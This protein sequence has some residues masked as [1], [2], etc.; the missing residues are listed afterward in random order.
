MTFSSLR[1]LCV[2]C[3]VPSLL[4]MPTLGGG[5]L[6]DHTDSSWGLLRWAS[7]VAS[8]GKPFTFPRLSH[9]SWDHS[10]AL[11]T[12]QSIPAVYL[13]WKRQSKHSSVSPQNLKSLCAAEWQNI[14]RKPRGLFSFTLGGR[15]GK[16]KKKQQK[17]AHFESLWL[18]LVLWSFQREGMCTAHMHTAWSRFTCGQ[19]EQYGGCGLKI[20]VGTGSLKTGLHLI[21]KLTSRAQKPE[22]DLL[23]L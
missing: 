10:P 18:C 13:G 3:N 9:S 7:P 15:V 14:C 19:P 23:R 21:F 17:P 5:W 1:H 11:Q 6:W 16:K 12:C 4:K 22:T 20:S 2:P 8:Q